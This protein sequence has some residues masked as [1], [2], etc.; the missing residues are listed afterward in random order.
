MLAHHGA[1]WRTKLERDIGN[2][3]ELKTRLLDERERSAGDVPPT[4]QI[5]LKKSGLHER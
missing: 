5:A 3:A 1:L 2:F 4:D